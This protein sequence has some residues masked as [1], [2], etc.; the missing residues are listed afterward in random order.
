[1]KLTKGKGV[2]VL[3]FSMLVSSVLAMTA[4]LTG[5]SLGA[6]ANL[7]YPVVLGIL[8]ILIFLLLSGFSKAKVIIVALVI[9]FGANIYMGYLLH[10]NM[11]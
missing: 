2:I 10:Y 8:S 7:I 3:M 11:I 4:D 6:L 5:A 1:M 9:L